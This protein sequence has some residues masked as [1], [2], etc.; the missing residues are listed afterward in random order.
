MKPTYKGPIPAPSFHEPVWD[1]SFDGKTIEEN[2]TLQQIQ[3]ASGG[4]VVTDAFTVFDL[5]S[6]VHKQL[7]FEGGNTAR[8]Q[9]HPMNPALLA[10]KP[11]SFGT[12]TA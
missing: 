12:V 5:K 4:R 3:H 7:V 2:L 11:D 10:A 8:V 9:V 6:G 1:A